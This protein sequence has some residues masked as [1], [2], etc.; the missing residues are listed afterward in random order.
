MGAEDVE[1]GERGAQSTAFAHISS[2]THAE[3]CA[4]THAGKCVCM[5]EIV[6]SK[7]NEYMIHACVNVHAHNRESHAD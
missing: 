5:Q 1:E 3:K 6:Q 4:R 7:R 2:C